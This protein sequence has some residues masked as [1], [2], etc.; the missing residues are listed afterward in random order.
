MCNRGPVHSNS[1]RNYKGSSEA[2]VSGI[3]RIID[4]CLGI[5][6]VN[7]HLSTLR[8]MQ[9]SIYTHLVCHKSSCK[10]NM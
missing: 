1:F 3:S 8:Y 2:T 6:D 10:E 4:I 5:D 9:V 7:Q